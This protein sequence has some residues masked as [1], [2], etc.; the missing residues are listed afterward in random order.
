M[1]KIFSFGYLFCC[2]LGLILTRVGY[3]NKGIDSFLPLEINS[4]KFINSIKSTK[5]SIKQLTHSPI[6]SAQGDL[7]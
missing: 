6:F 3:Q 2:Y 7:F 4:T 5:F 1:L